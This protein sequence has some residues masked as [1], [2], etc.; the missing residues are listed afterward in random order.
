MQSIASPFL[1]AKYHL[2]VKYHDKLGWTNFLEGRVFSYF[3]QLQREYIS[4]CDTY[5][6]AE[7]WALGF[8]EH[9]IRITHRQWLHRNAKVH[10]KR[11]DGRTISQHE[12]IMEKIKDLLWTDPEELLDDDKA[13][14]DED[15]E[16]LGLATATNREFWVASMEAAISAAEHKRRRDANHTEDEQPK[17]HILSDP[18]FDNEGSLR[19]RKRRRK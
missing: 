2:L 10:F 14:L 7:T 1:P 18:E 4:T 15:F 13:L 9:L 5:Q 6:T 8:M 19:Y 3:V 12:Q 11:S 17:N 16:Q